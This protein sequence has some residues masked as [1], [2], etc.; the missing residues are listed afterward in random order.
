MLFFPLVYKGFV[1]G[2]GG[3]DGF[4]V[5]PFPLQMLKF[6]SLGMRTSQTKPRKEIYTS[7]GSDQDLL[8]LKKTR[9]KMPQVE[10]L[11]YLPLF[12]SALLNEYI[13]K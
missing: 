7:A 3:G 2:E 8:T 13:N 5:L 11:N 9:R 4:L 6:S 10:E 12:S 1:F